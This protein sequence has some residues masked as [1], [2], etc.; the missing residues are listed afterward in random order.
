MLR[1]YWPARGTSE[2]ETAKL[3][4]TVSRRGGGG[5]PRVTPS[6]GGTR[7]KLIFVAEFRKNTRWTTWEGGSGE[8]TAALS[9]AMTK[10]VVSFFF[11][12]K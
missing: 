5:P 9:K 2:K 1:I 3:G 10:K 8:E 7:M 4:Q 12:E 11:K 6:R